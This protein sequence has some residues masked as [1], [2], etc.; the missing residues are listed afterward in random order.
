MQP[1]RIDLSYRVC[2]QTR[3]VLALTRLT[4]AAPLRGSDATGRERLASLASQASGG[5]ARWMGL[6]FGAELLLAAAVFGAKGVT[7]AGIV[8]ALS[9]TARVAFPLFWLA[10]AGGALATLFGRR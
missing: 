3:L 5:V 9:L 8:L 6:A 1:S 10:Y 7:E 4:E 2:L